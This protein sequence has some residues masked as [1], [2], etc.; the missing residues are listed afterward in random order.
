MGRNESEQSGINTKTSGQSHLTLLHTLKGHT[1]IVFS[2]AWS[3]DGRVLASCSEDKTIRLWDEQTGRLLH[4][5]EGNE[6][7]INSVVW[8]PDG[9]VLVS[10]S[11][12]KTIGLWDGKSGQHLSTLEG[13]TG[14][15]SG[16]SFSNDGRLLAS[17][18][19]D[20]TVRI[21]R[22]VS[23]ETVEILNEECSHYLNFLGVAFQPHAPMLATVGEKNTV[24]HIWNVDVESLLRTVP[25]TAS[26]HYTTVHYSKN[27]VGRR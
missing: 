7:S 25:P 4:T 16:I 18:S 20:G 27:C 8:S 26:V 5:R 17:K 21:W 9:R 22:T 10:G 11:G 12:D 15:V 14:P 2:V 23:W 1:G 3:P 19:Y 6:S 24:I 13:H